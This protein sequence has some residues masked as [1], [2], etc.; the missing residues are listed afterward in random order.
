MWDHETSSKLSCWKIIREKKKL[1]KSVLCFW[2]QKAQYRPKGSN[3]LMSADY[4]T[5][6]HKAA[7]GNHQWLCPLSLRILS[8]EIG[9][10]YREAGAT[11]KTMA[12][13]NCSW[14]SGKHQPLSMKLQLF[15]NTLA[16]GTSIV[17]NVTGAV[18][19]H[20]CSCTPF[21]TQPRIPAVFPSIKLY[22]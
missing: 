21:W 17:Q 9:N 19:P 8:S 4:S 5:C 6:L 18:L 13:A 12:R 10:A 16:L 15:G 2:S 20:Y 22:R 11:P 3:V 14:T 1:S 7:R